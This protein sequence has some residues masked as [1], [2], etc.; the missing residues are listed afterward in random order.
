VPIMAGHVA[1]F[2]IEF[3]MVRDVYRYEIKFRI[4]PSGMLT[5]LNSGK[6]QDFNGKEAFT[7]PLTQVEF[8]E[9]LREVGEDCG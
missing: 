2:P 6:L 1:R 5:N 3:K 7:R 9:V 4:I 8:M